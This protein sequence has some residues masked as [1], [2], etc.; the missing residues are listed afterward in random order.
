MLGDAIL[1]MYCYIGKVDAADSS[2]LGEVQLLRSLLMRV[3]VAHPLPLPKG[4][5]WWRLLAEKVAATAP[6]SRRPGS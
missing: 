5:R 6:W 3:D 1:L 2:P 4:L